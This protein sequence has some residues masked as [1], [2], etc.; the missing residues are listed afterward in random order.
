MTKRESKP[1][2]QGQSENDPAPGFQMTSEEALRFIRELQE[3]FR[4]APRSRAEKAALE[5]AVQGYLA[6]FPAAM[7]KA[8]G[9]RVQGDLMLRPART[10][11]AEDSEAGSPRPS[12]SR[13]KS[14]ATTAG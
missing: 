9:R 14:K 13:K 11:E 8:V 6:Q 10:I 7:L 5:A 3:T 2:R 4:E 12:G 1:S